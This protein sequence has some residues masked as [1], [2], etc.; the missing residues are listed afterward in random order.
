M[1][2]QRMAG[3]QYVGAAWP[4]VPPQL[5]LD[6]GVPLNNVTEISHNIFERRWSKATVS[7]NCSSMEGSIEWL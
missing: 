6:Y 7:M 4:V 2:G 5:L 1:A 3:V